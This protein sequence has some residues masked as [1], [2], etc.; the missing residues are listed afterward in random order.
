MLIVCALVAAH[1]VVGG[2]D[3]AIDEH[4]R[5]RLGLRRTRDR[6]L[7]ADEIT[8]EVDET[9]EPGLDRGDLRG[10]LAPPRLVTLLDAHDVHRVGAEVDHPVGLPRSRERLVQLCHLLDRTVQLPAELAHIRDPQRLARHSRHLDLLSGQPAE[11]LVGEIGA[12]ERSEHLARTRPGHGQQTR[13]VGDVADGHILARLDVLV[14]PVQVMGGADDR[15]V[16]IEAVSGETADRHLTLDSAQ[17]S[18]HVHQA[19][20]A[21]AA[22]NPV[23]REPV[24]QNRG[25]STGHLELGEGGEVGDAD[26]LAGPGDFTSHEVESVGTPKRVPFGI[27]EVLRTLPPVHLLPLRA[28][29][30]EAVVDRVDLLAARHR[31]LL[32]GQA[33]LV[34]LVVLVDRLLDG[35]HR[36]G[37]RVVSE[38]A[39]VHRP[40]V[41]LS[42]AVHDPLGEVLACSRTLGDA[43]GGAVAMPVVAKPRGRPHEI[44]RIGSMGDRTRDDLLDPRFGPGRDPQHRQFETLGDVVDVG[45]RE[46]EVESPV[47]P[48]DAVDLG[49]GHLIG[50]DQQPVDLAAVVAAR[51]GI[52]GHRRFEAETAHRLER[53]GDDVLVDDR[54]DRHVEP[55][56]RSQLRGVVAGSVDHV[57]AGDRAL[58]G[59]DLPAAV[60]QLTHFD[61]TVVALDLTAELTGALG[62]RIGAACGVGPTVVGRVEPGLHI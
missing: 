58:L 56:H 17:L 43:D 53:L 1:I 20:T 41:D 50:P 27:T 62:H 28:Q 51:P 33:D 37:A 12:G 45:R 14:Q 19:D 24:E 25:I 10:Q 18:Q 42:L 8:V 48:V 49:V 46:I 9:L 5:Q 15:R 55:D 16:E 34:H 2:V 32:A 52:S 21:V 39:W 30:V 11:R 60:G 31:P 38:A 7:P 22:R 3:L 54:D 44:T 40:N 35:E 13:R 47:D 61:H 23:G 36:L 57:L 59:H 26:P 29:R 4:H 6:G